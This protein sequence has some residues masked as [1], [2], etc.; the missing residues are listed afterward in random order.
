MKDKAVGQFIFGIMLAIAGL[1][2]AALV[3]IVHFIAKVW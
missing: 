3:V 2:V 1:F